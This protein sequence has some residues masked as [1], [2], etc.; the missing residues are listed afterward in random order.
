MDWFEYLYPLFE[1]ASYLGVFTALVLCG[2]GLP[3]PEEASFIVAG[4]L[5]SIGKARLG[6]MIVTGL[7]GVLV[8]DFCL[9]FLAK[10]YGETILRHW[11]FRAMFS[12][13]LFEKSRRFFAK[14]GDNAVFTAGFFA[15]VRATTFFLSATLGFRFSKFLFWDFLRVIL[16]CPI[17]IWAGYKFG[18]YA[19]EWL[20]ARFIW[21]LA[22]IVIVGIVVT[23]R[24]ANS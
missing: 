5:V 18:P 16:T 17:S 10:N 22:A 15:G 11:P 2:M 23:F 3:V 21:I 24:K 6:Y 14:H 4:Y 9:F 7:A 12:E 8:G 20:G 13:K 19:D 1:S